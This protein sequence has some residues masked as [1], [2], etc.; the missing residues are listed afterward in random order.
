[1]YKYKTIDEK[2][3]HEISAIMGSRFIA[4]AYPVEKQWEAKSIIH[5]IHKQHPSA[6]HVC[7]AYRTEVEA[8]TDLFGITTVESAIHYSYDAWEPP[9]TAWKPIERVL[10]SRSLD[11][12]LIAVVRYFWGKKLGIGGLIK[13]YTQAAQEIASLV[14][15]VEREVQITISCGFLL[16]ELGIFLHVLQNKGRHHEYDILDDKVEAKIIWALSEE[17]SMKT[18]ICKHMTSIS[19]A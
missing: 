19:R 15:I 6:T 2:R 9:Y 4:Y 7:Y 17:D 1:M 8:K 10:Q 13:A 18:I 14:A 12:T 3:V 16:S 5:E 11:N